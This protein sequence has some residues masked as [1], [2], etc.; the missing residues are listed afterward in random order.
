MFFGL[1]IFGIT[2]ILLPWQIISAIGFVRGVFLW[3][4][5]MFGSYTWKQVGDVRY[6]IFNANNQTVNEFRKSESTRTDRFEDHLEVSEFDRFAAE[7]YNR[8]YVDWKYM[9]GF[10]PDY[11]DIDD[12]SNEEFQR[13]VKTVE[14]YDSTV[15]QERRDFIETIPKLETEVNHDAWGQAI[16]QKLPLI[17]IYW[18]ISFAAMI[19]T[20]D[21]I[22]EN[23]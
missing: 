1:A 4:A 23:A 13:Y 10:E 7:R 9:D 8:D 11:T 21:G 20:L 14:S 16:Y 12:Y 17:F 22:K 19:S 18:I 15:G 6:E 3:F 5:I 2:C